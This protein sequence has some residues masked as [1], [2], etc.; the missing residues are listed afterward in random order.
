M[1]VPSDAVIPTPKLTCYLLVKQKR[2]DKSKFLSQAGFTLDNYEALEY[3]LR[4]LTFSN[5]AIE[6]RTE[7]YGTFYSVKGQIEGPNSR[8]LDVVTIWLQRR[9]DKK[10]QFVTLVPKK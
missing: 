9:V 6:D 5:K 4:Q 2:N 8:K 1:K 7:E 10:F 3:A